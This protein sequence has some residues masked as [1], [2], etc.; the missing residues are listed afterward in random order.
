MKVLRSL[1]A[2]NSRCTVVKHERAVRV[3]LNYGAKLPAIHDERVIF[4]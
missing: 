4:F 2:G 3:Q 1:L